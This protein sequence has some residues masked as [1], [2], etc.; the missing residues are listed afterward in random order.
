[1]K[2]GIVAI[3]VRFS[4]RP[5]NGRSNRIGRSEQGI[6]GRVDLGHA[7]RIASAVRMSVHSKA[8]IG[9]L[10]LLARRAFAHTEGAAGLIM[11]RHWT[12]RA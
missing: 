12:L 5:K 7:L 11:Q 8:P 10:D 3:T 4:R 9:L 6:A 1:M 2:T